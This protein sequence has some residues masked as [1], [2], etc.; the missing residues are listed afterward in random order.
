MSRLNSAQVGWRYSD[1]IRH[2]NV[3]QLGASR[4]DCRAET[5]TELKP[6]VEGT[7]FPG[8][9]A[10]SGSGCDADRVLYADVRP[11]A[12]SAKACRRPSRLE[13]AIER[14]ST[15]GD[16]R[17]EPDACGPLGGANA[18]VDRSTSLLARF[19]HV[20]P[21]TVEV[22]SLDLQLAKLLGGD[23]LAGGMAARRSSAHVQRARSGWS[24]CR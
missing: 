24:C 1:G 15:G 12:A 22:V 7:S 14:V 6:R 20:V 19:D 23:L 4:A 21:I 16:M 13:L 10:V 9:I 17:A 8:E 2:A 3:R 5:S 11:L 18:E